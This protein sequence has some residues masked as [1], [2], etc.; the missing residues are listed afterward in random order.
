M[1]GLEELIWSR[2]ARTSMKW[3]SVHYFIY[4]TG[5]SDQENGGKRFGKADTIIDTSKTI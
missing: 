1:V 2:N 3:L 5:F 4:Q